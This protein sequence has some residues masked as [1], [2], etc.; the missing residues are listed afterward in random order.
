MAH[1]RKAP[2]TGRPIIDNDGPHTSWA[3]IW[4]YI[5]G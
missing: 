1:K 2:A 4:S 5:F 3:S